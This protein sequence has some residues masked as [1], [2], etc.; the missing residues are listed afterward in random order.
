MD[1]FYSIVTGDENAF[2]KLCMALPEI[3][4]EVV[5]EGNSI[6]I[7]EDTVI[8][9]LRK[10]SELYK[11]KSCDLA[12]AMAVYMLGFSTY[13]GFSGSASSF[14]YESESMTLNRIYEY[15]KYMDEDIKG[16]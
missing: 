5:D 13:S 1:Q 3:I 9:E 16:N 4:A 10:V 8:A 7:P 15:G 2:Y 11:D 6:E 12:M 14:E